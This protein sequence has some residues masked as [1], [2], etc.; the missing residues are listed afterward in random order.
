MRFSTT[1]KLVILGF[2]QVQFYTFYIGL[3]PC[4][5]E[6]KFWK[7]KKNLSP[8]CQVSQ[9]DKMVVTFRSLLKAKAVDAAKIAIKC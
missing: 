7:K 9:L 3:K 2:K 4:K 8:L 1:Q 6:G 5:K